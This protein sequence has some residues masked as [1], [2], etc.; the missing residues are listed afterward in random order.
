MSIST[1]SLT[2]PFNT[3]AGR[4]RETSLWFALLALLCLFAADLELAVA[5]PWLELKRMGQGLLSPHIWSWRELLLALA[6]TL[7]FALQGI[8][9][10]AVA[11]FGLSLLYRHR[12][13]RAFCAFIRAIH[14]L[15]WAL[16]F[17]Q[18]FGLSPLTGVLAIALPYAG[19]LAKIYGELFEET[20]PAP[21]NN[22]PMG[23]SSS[24]GLSA[25]FYTTLPLALRPLL[26][27]TS[28]RFEC[29]IRS[30][31]V[32]GFIGLPTLGYHLETALKEGQYSEAAA[33]LY[34]MVAAIISLRFWL[35]R[36]LVP[37]YLLAAVI[38]L[39]PSASLSLKMAL[40]F[41]T[42]DIVPAPIRSAAMEGVP[43]SEWL[44]GLWVWLTQL[45]HAQLW[46]GLWDTLILS[47]VALVAT[48]LVTL[49]SFPLNSRLFFSAPLRGVGD[50]WLV[51]MRSTPE[52]L[53]AF[54]GLL[55]F[56]P[57]M[58]PAIIALAL[59]NGAIIAHLVGQ[60]T[61]AMSLR[62]DAS[63]GLNRYF[64]EV[65]PR[66]YRQL[67][68]FL[69]YRW[70]VIMRET[71]ILGILGISTLG[72]YIDSAFEEFRFDRAMVLI[73]AAAM[74]NMVVDQLARWMRRR[75]HLKT[76]PECL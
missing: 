74:L 38:F 68:A 47:Q 37:F 56:G 46:P 33:L 73:M 16:I 30:S 39:P 31:V 43:Y 65:L 9:L 29:A 5:D 54:I 2:G 61:S 14:E 13:V 15:F 28:Y 51:V 34:V 58:L 21:R 7:A 26:T 50:G 6:N 19:T 72:F 52:Y 10:A 41:I 63:H 75:L 49:V 35:R 36:R 11:G 3:S 20:D 62:D 18:V 53:L 40:R 22:L 17:I 59:H 1:R 25:F 66:V 57:S 64:Y 71:A 76:T 12:S 48:A 60:Y 8:A 44:E 70:E 69:F 4:L 32:L 67:L 42:E 24:N 45:W 55:V 27:Y 23:T